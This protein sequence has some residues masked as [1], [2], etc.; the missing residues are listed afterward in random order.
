MAKRDTKFGSDLMDALKEVHAHRRGEIA[1]PSR[2]IDVLSAQRVKAIRMA[3]AKSPKDFER[4]FGI[5]ARTLEGWEQ[6]RKLD[7][8]SSILMTVIEAKPDAVE[9]S[10]AKARLN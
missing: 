7:V 8:A 6:G 10:V 2:K 9:A 4:R 5:P 1:L 3:L